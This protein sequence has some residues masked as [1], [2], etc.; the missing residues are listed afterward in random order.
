[1]NP[2]KSLEILE[3]L[4]SI[5][6]KVRKTVKIAPPFKGKNPSEMKILF[7]VMHG[8]PCTLKEISSIVGLAN[9]TV[10]GLI[11]NLERDGYVKR[12]QDEKDRRRII[13][14]PTDKANQEKKLVEDKFKSYL[15]YV[16]VDAYEEEL[17]TVIKGLR[18]L[19]EII[20]RK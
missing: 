17:E 8:P 18:K 1:M 4:S 14:L 19:E 6:K 20:D 11:D 7:N 5:N 12:V 10:C 15:D 9:S 16:L 2:N 13:I 3:I